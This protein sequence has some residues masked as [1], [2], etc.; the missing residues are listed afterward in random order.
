[1]EL[2]NSD[3]EWILT[4]V[5]GG[6]NIITEQKKKASKL[7]GLKHGLTA[8]IQIGADLRMQSVCIHVNGMRFKYV[9][10][11]ACMHAGL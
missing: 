4:K 3:S 11:A 8:V 5:I 2:C 9:H 7:V 10:V 6:G 1:M